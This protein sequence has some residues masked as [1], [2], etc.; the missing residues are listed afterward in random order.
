M[1]RLWIDK[2]WWF[3]AGYG[4]YLQVCRE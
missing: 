4:E 1:A 3:I 2:K